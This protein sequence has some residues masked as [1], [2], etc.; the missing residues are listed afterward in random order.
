MAERRYNH[1]VNSMEIKVRLERKGLQAPSN[2]SL[3]QTISDSLFGKFVIA[4]CTLPA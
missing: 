3:K 1:L 4:L 2:Y